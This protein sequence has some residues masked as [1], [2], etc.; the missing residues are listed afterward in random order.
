VADKAGKRPWESLTPCLAGGIRVLSDRLDAAR[1]PVAAPS[2]PNLR[3]LQ[4][5]Q[6]DAAR[7]TGRIAALYNQVSDGSLVLEGSLKE[8][9]RDQQSKLTT[10]QAEIDTLARSQQLPLRKFG[11]QQIEAF[12]VAAQDA[13]LDPASKKARGYLRSVVSEIRVRKSDALL[14]SN[15]AQLAGVIATWKPDTVPTE[16]SFI[17]EWRARQESNL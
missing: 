5:A 17:S 7:Q 13:L 6:S 9:I 12:A 8:Y 1:K 4:S 3:R 11:R 2:E 10:L 16:P 15:R 14:S